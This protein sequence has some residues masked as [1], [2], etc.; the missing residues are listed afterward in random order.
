MSESKTL[1]TSTLSVSTLK[2]QLFELSSALAGPW[3]VT[4]VFFSTVIFALWHLATN[5][6]IFEPG[7]W[8]NAIHF[9]GFAFLAALTTQSFQSGTTTRFSILANLVFGSLIAFSSLWIA[10][11][12][13]TYRLVCRFHGDHRGY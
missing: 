7:N 3:Y 5:V 1:A 8:Q 11:A 6:V 4:L 12:V 9:A 2:D 10:L 13:W